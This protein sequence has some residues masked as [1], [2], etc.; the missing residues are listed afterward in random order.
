MNDRASWHCR[1]RLDKYRPHEAD[2][3][4]VVEGSGNLL[5][6]AGANLL[7]NALTSGSVTL[8]TNANAHLGVGD[9]TLPASAAQ[10]DLQAVSS[11]FRRRVDSA[12]PVVAGNQ[13]TFRATFG[14]SEANFAW[15]EWGL[16]NAFAGGTML[17]RKVQALGTKTSGS[18][19]VFTVTITLS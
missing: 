3:H 11:K 6:T 1:W 12:Y 10:T 18:T 17:N 14:G 2:P 9:S 16:F 7:W 4:E 15:N 19:W 13:V 5:T 8:L